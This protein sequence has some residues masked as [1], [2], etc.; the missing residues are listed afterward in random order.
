M[1]DI[2]SAPEE[3]KEPK[4][5]FSGG[6]NRKEHLAKEAKYIDDIKAFLAKNGY[7]GKNMG[8]VIRFPVADGYAQYMVISMRPLML[9]HLPLGDAYNFQYAHLLTEKEVNQK[10]KQQ[11]AL[12]K[13]FSGE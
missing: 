8:K 2:Y 1:A 11:E 9:M 12:D 4:I 13:L 10:V 5:D 7:K 6:F 3:I